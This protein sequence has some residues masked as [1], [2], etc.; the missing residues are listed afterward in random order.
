MNH[1]R[2][3]RVYAFE[4]LYA[5]TFSRETA[6]NTVLN[7]THLQGKANQF[8]EQLITGVRSEKEQLDAALQEFSPKRKME[9]FPKVELTILRMAAW[10]L[11]HPQA[12]TPAKIVINEAVLLAKEFGGSTSYKYINAILHNLA[13]SRQ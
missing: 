4:T 11:L 5:D 2:L 10:E 3:A 9:R 6:D 13:T 7:T 12:D 1:R 8:A